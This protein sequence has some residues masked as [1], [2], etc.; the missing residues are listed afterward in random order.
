[1]AATAED[2]GREPAAAGQQDAAVPPKFSFGSSTLLSAFARDAAEPERSEKA[3]KYDLVAQMMDT[4]DSDS[5]SDAGSDAAKS[6]AAEVAPKKPRKK[7]AAKSGKSSAR[8]RAAPA[9]RSRAIGD[10][11]S[12]D[13]P[14]QGPSARTGDG[15]DPG[16]EPGAGDAGSPGKEPVGEDG[17]RGPRAASK[18][19]MELMHRESERLVRET[20]VKID[21]DDFT[22]RLTLDDYF[23]RFD[24]RLKSPEAA[25]PPKRF[26]VPPVQVKGSFAFKLGDGDGELVVVEDSLAQQSQAA[27]PVLVG[28]VRSADAG[29]RVHEGALDAIL[30][31]GSQSLHKL[32]AKAGTQRIDG[33]LAL[34]ALNTALLDV[35]YKRDA[36]AKHAKAA[37]RS[38]RLRVKGDEAEPDTQDQAGSDQAPAEE[39]DGEDVDG[40]EEVEEGDGAGQSSGEEQ[41]SDGEQSGSEAED[42]VADERAGSA[43]QARGRRREVVSSDEEQADEDDRAG[44]CAVP[45]HAPREG[46]ATSAAAKA[47]FLG[48]FRMPAREAP[49]NAAQAA[50]T[51]AAPSEQHEPTG[52]SQRDSQVAHSQDVPGLFTSQIGGFGTQDSLLL[53]PDGEERPLPTQG[54]VPGDG[55]PDRVMFPPGSPTQSMQPTQ[56]LQPTQPTTATAPATQST[57]P[58]MAT[59]EASES[60]SA[61]PSMVRQALEA[62]GQEPDPEPPSDQPRP[63]EDAP[64]PRQGPRLLRRGGAD[65]A[66]RT[67]P[68]RVK[69][70][71]F[72]EAEAEEGEASDSD[73]EPGV[74]KS[75]KFNWSGNDVGAASEESEEDDLDMD[76]DEEEEALRADPMID[77][78][79]EE[80]AEGDEAIR[81]LHRQQDFDRDER[82]IQELFKD[83]T[84]GGLRSRALRN[85]TGFA[86]A[87][88]EDYIDRQTRAERMEERLRRRRRLLAREIHDTNLAEIAKNPETAAFA[89]AA[90][91]RP[92]AAAGGA[93]SEA[94]DTEDELP[95]GEGF[96]LEE[97]V[98]ERSV[99]ATI[100]RHLV[101]GSRRADSDTGSD[102]ED[103][104]AAASS[105]SAPLFALDG[106]VDDGLGGD[107]FS[108]V[109]IERL[110]MYV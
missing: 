6:A 77:H 2:G 65:R 100:Q 71:E 29:A 103:S 96:G 104:Q 73:G 88:D 91:M 55:L 93:Q 85:R 67:K 40:E 5:D 60:G 78:N 22:Q 13:E 49:P 45:P 42:N 66:A 57:A 76:T 34:R 24:A 23:E 94:T 17:A 46:G 28:S 107:V 19:A 52:P 68:R 38:R 33:P 51:P 101:R 32:A 39:L 12:D 30:N 99:A 92:P 79:V 62:Y 9:K 21:P 10:D 80:D 109:P 37:K 89:R 72:V 69:R 36:E 82:D 43:Q 1:M 98:D 53:T 70:S 44:P 84:T 48:M 59:A 97:E 86:L 4:D 102:A 7:A 108:A 105:V 11:S 106:H 61:L 90:L 20:A 74:V 110:I 3:P 64:A 27:L 95:G 75:R 25:R 35:V 63:Q 47:K 26:V 83:V 87:D 14:A 31:Y 58:T 56:S 81:D 54:A 8:P 50:S 15:A 16:A 18:A 41:S